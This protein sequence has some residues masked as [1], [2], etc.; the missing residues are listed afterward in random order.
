[1]EFKQQQQKNW[2][3][4]LCCHLIVRHHHQKKNILLLSNLNYIGAKKIVRSAGGPVRVIHPSSIFFKWNKTGWE[5]CLI[6]PTKMFKGLFLWL[7]FHPDLS[8][9]Y[10]YKLISIRAQVVWL[11]GRY[12]NAIESKCL[13]SKKSSSTRWTREREWINNK[14][15]PRQN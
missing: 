13:Q 8:F 1:M 2:G 6:F 14:V 5:M 10:Y 9:E 7:V 4:L 15:L 12:V 11:V 3:R